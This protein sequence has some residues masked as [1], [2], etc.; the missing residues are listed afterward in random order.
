M[1]A[2]LQI[3][4]RTWQWKNF[5]NRPVFDEVKRR[6]RWLTFLAHPVQEYFSMMLKTLTNFGD[7]YLRLGVTIATANLVTALITREWLLALASVPGQ[8][9]AYCLTPRHIKWKC[10]ISLWKNKHILTK[11]ALP[12]QLNL[13]KAV[14]Y[15]S[16]I[17]DLQDLQDIHC[18]HHVVCHAQ[19]SVERIHQVCKEQ[20]QRGLWAQAVSGLCA[21]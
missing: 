17:F 20:E 15:I 19:K 14:H 16:V 3:S 4:C 13:I 5:K 8:P 11:A 10:K 21:H 18:W 12:S 2:L 6:M 9:I 7:L 1:I